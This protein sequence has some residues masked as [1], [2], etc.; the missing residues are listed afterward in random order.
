[1]NFKKEKVKFDFSKIPN[2]VGLQ[3]IGATCYMNATLQVLSNTD[4][5][6]NIF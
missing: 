6:I 5:F 1:M 2:K 3:N 4:D